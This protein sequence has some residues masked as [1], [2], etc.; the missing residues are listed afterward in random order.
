MD[1]RAELEALFEGVLDQKLDSGKVA[2]PDTFRGKPGEDINSWICKFNIAAKS[3]GWN[4]QKKM[5]KLPGYLSDNALDFYSLVI[6][7]DEVNYDSCEAILSALKEKF[8]PSN[9]EHVLREELENL[10]QGDESVSAFLLTVMK[11]C[12][13]VDEDM[14]EKEMI[15][16]ALKG[17]NPKISRPVY[18]QPR[19]PLPMWRKLQE[20]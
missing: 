19:K 3:N 11:K 5:H 6:M 20:V 10:K 8:L 13:Q 7:E 16:I 4:E 18:A 17:M 9:Y 14:P 15:R 2:K 12:K 1:G